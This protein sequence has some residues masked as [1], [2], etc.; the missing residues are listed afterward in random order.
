MLNQV[1]VSA[2]FSILDYVA[3][4]K[5]YLAAYVIEKANW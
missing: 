4:E 5:G 2:G 3:D 1:V